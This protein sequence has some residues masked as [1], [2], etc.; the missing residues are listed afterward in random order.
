MLALSRNTKGIVQLGCVVPRRGWT[1]SYVTDIIDARNVSLVKTAIKLPFSK[2]GGELQRVKPESI[3]RDIG[4]SHLQRAIFFRRVRVGGVQ[5]K[6]VVFFVF[7][8][9]QQVVLEVII[10]DLALALDEK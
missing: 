4:K 7:G 10:Q 3:L 5:D 2:L 9:A 8:N 6:T 1:S